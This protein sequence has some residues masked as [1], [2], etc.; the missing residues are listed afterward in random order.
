MTP[1]RRAAPLLPLA[2]L[3]A[4]AGCGDSTEAQQEIEAQ[5]EAIE[6]SYDAEAEVVEALAEG[7]PEPE[8]DAAEAR[9]KDLRQQGDSEREHLNNMA[10]ELDEIMPAQQPAQQ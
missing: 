3:V 9:A 8:Q 6:E 10:D 2:A 5:A 4:L 7:A 1:A